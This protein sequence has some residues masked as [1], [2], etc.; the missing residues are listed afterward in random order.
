MYSKLPAAYITLKITSPQDSSNCHIFLKNEFSTK[1]FTKFPATLFAIAIV[2]TQFL[3]FQFPV[4]W[5]ELE[6]AL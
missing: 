3:N 2:C 6:T 1:M 4:C 5:Q